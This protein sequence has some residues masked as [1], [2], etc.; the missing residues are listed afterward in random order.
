MLFSVL[1]SVYKSDNA[2]YFRAAFASIIEQSLKPAEVILV[3][4]GPVNK[5]LD[6]V[7]SELSAL[8]PAL[9]KVVVL[10]KN[11]G[12][13]YAL[14]IGLA[15]CTHDIV[16]RMDSDDIS[17][18]NRFQQQIQ[19]LQKNADIDLV[20]AWI[21]E[22]EGNIENVSSYRRTPET[23]D[24]IVRFSKRRSPFN[25][26]SVVFRKAAILE[27]GGYHSYGTFEDYILWARFLML[28]KKAYNIQQALVYFR[29]DANTY[30]RRGGFKKAMQEVRLQRDFFKMG[31]VS[32][33]EFCSN[34]ILR[35][36]VRLVPNIMRIMIYKIVNR[37]KKIKY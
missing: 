30:L 31:F 4:D 3:K 18:A 7:I 1:M 27:A 11:M 25:H 29:I 16:A 13:G 2:F 9:L 26:P 8:Y 6:L 36:C 14:D 32:L 23:H 24:E 10:E 20:G 5:D 12:L 33:P 19:V 22:F 21:A 15:Q 17:F 28:G 37:I 35:G 34:V